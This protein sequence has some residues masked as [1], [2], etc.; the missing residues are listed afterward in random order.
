MLRLESSS[1][2]IFLSLYLGGRADQNGIFIVGF[3]DGE[4]VSEGL[5]FVE[6][7]RDE[8]GV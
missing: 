4:R 8:V 1:Q 3:K 6:V 7:G 5:S 2:G